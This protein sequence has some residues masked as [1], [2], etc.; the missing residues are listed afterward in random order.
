MEMVPEFAK[1]VLRE[2]GEVSDLVETKFV[3]TY[4][5]LERKTERKTPR[6]GASTRASHT[7]WRRSE[8]ANRCGRHRPYAISRARRRKEKRKSPR[9]YREALHVTVRQT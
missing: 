5:S 2:A 3:S 7:D 8:N 1:G 4:Q 9:R 6:L